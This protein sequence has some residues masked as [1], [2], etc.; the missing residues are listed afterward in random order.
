[1]VNQETAAD[2]ESAASEWVARLDSDSVSAADRAALSAWLNRSDRHRG[3]F[4]RSQAIG[5]AIMQEM[6]D[7][8]V[9]SSSEPSARFSRRSLVAWAATAV[10]VSVAGAWTFG[11][12]TYPSRTAIE[13]EIGEIKRVPLDETTVALLNTETELHTWYENGLRR[14]QLIR[15]EALFFVSGAAL[16]VLAV[17]AGLLTAR[18]ASGT[19]SV[20]NVA[21]SLDFLV[22]GGAISLFEGDGTPLTNV[23]AGHLAELAGSKLTT[24]LVSAEQAEKRLAWRD[25]VIVLDQETVGAAVQLFNRYNRLKLVA[26]DNLARQKLV[27]RFSANDPRGF[28]ESVATA[29]DARIQA[30]PT[31]IFLTSSGGK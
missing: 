2:I 7:P 5:S 15:G 16:P 18:T 27:G 11:M 9:M 20:S 3:A 28:A 12:Q 8:A 24:S 4:V 23:V 14:V 17:T 1:M 19:F 31:E 29:F 21:Q 13:T 10:G 30:G 6:S 25:G 22:T 26:S